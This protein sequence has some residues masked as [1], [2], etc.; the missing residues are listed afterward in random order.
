MVKCSHGKMFNHCEGSD[1]QLGE[2][3]TFGYSKVCA[4]QM[5][6]TDGGLSAH[7]KDPA[8]FYAHG[9]VYG[10]KPLKGVAEFEVE[11]VRYGSG[12]S[13]TVKLGIVKIAENKELTVND[14]PRYSP[15]AIGYCVWCADKVHN[16]LNNATPVET[17]YGGHNLDSLREGS[18]V[19][20][21]LERNG[22]L[23]FL[24]DGLSQGVACK[25][26]TSKGHKL[27]VV[28]DHYA[29]CIETKITRSGELADKYPLL[30]WMLILQSVLKI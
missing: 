4:S 14:V 19:G 28:V 29:N 25:N 11:I 16:N 5:E 15:D 24:V 12:W 21:R 27:F 18:R 1:F 26:T 17:P 8:Q 7:K 20:L 6:V 2:V 10:D 13:G 30:G 22:D 9:V 3:V 23:S